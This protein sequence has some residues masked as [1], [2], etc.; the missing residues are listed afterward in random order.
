[1]AWSAPI[2]ATLNMMFTAAQWNTNVRD[3][4]NATEAGKATTKGRY[5]VS[6]GTNSI[7]E[8]SWYTNYNTNTQSTTST[9]YANLSS[10]GPSVTVS[11][12]TS[13]IVWWSCAMTNTT[14]GS[15]AWVSP[16]VS[17]ATTVAASDTWAIMVDD[18]TAGT[19]TDNSVRMSG[20]HRFTGLTSGSNT[21]ILK[22]RVSANTGWFGAR[23]IQVMPA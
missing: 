19:A 4:L 7:T 13:A 10:S 22:Y 18:I 21:F 9:S 16:A 5:F 15:E 1:M 6:A 11:T 8:R 14:G 17:G 2:T 3:N 20:M 23:A 12:G